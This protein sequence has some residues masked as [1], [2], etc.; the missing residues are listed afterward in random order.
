MSGFKCLK[1]GY[2][3]DKDS[4][5]CPECGRE[6]QSDDAVVARHLALLAKIVWVLMIVSALPLIRVV[7]ALIRGTEVPVFPVLILPVLVGLL[8]I[9]KWLCGIC[10]RQRSSLVP[11][12][13]GVF[14]G[15]LV[16]VA[17]EAAMVV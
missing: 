5:R 6:C 13:F 12:A 1:C 9:E 11:V 16:L 17:A 4:V 7:W 14:V 15:V 2:S 10:I 3:L 8:L